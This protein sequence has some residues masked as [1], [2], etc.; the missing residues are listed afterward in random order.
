SSVRSQQLLAQLAELRRDSHLCDVT[1][2]AE[3]T[4]INA[5][6]VVLAASSNYFKAMFTND[7]AESRMDEIEMVNIKAPTLETLVNYCYTGRIEISGT[8]VLSILPAAGLLQLNEVQEIV[9][10]EAFQ[11]LSFEQLLELISRDELGVQ[12]EDQVF[13]AVI[14]WIMFDLPARERFLPE[15]LPTSTNSTTATT[16]RARTAHP[17]AETGELGSRW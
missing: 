1:L 3:G 11:Q 9:G 16:N 2:V 15:N 13:D 12:A 14:Q 6:R 5:H 17:T 10:T 7:M 4:R 8:N